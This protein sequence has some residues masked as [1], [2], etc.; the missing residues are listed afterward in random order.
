MEQVAMDVIDPLPK[1]PR[2]N[3]FVLVVVDYFTRW[4][5]A[6]AITDQT[7]QTVSQKLVEECV[8]RFGVMQQLRTDQGKTF[9]SNLFQEMTKILGI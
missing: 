4:P 9:Q 2:G 1:T 6:Y 3:R 7:A 8:S 5:E